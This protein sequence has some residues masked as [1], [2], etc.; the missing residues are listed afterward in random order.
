MFGMYFWRMYMCSATPNTTVPTDFPRL[1]AIFQ[2][3]LRQWK[4][5]DRH[6]TQKTFQNTIEDFN[7][8]ACLSHWIHIV[9]CFPFPATNS[10][11]F[12]ADVSVSNPVKKSS[13]YE[14]CIYGVK[15]NQ[16]ISFK[17]DNNITGH[18][19]DAQR[20]ANL[21]VKRYTRR[22]EVCWDRTNQPGVTGWEAE[23]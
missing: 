12:I 6:H 2:G 7:S 5:S 3:Y 4:H 19:L 15:K 9:S 17:S 20:A 10:C 21:W 14:I 8:G 23:A 18:L 22:R 13:H 16:H 1:S 11:S